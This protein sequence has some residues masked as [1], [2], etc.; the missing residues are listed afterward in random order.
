MGFQ[1][2]VNTAEIVIEFLLNTKTVKNV[3]YAELL[4]GYNLADLTI[5]ADVVDANVAAAWLNDMTVDIDYVQTIVRG[6]EFENDQEVTVNTGAGPGTNLAGAL[7]GNVTIAIKKTS[8][9]TGRSARGRLYWNGV[10][11]T[12]L[13]ANENQM[14]QAN[15]DDIVANLGSMRA[16]INGTIWT[17]VLV[18]RFTAGAERPQGITFPWL[19]E[20]AVNRNM[21]SQRRRL[22]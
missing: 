7:P 9:K 5:L 15:L 21:D 2:V 12:F 8:G 14:I 3:L 4:G 10:P 22:L 11:S 16:S 18:S 20:S 19:G 17:S 1:K 6:L 13:S